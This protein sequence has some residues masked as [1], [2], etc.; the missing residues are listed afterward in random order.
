ML[1]A[2]DLS[3]N[4]IEGDIKEGDFAATILDAALKETRNRDGTMLVLTLETD[5][6]VRIVDRLNLINKSQKAEKIGR[7]RLKTLL[8]HCGLP[9]D[10][11]QYASILVGKRL[12]IRVK[13]ES[14]PDGNDY[15]RVAKY[16]SAQAPKGLSENLPPEGEAPPPGNTDDI[17]F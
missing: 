1:E 11:F 2:I 13:K 10:N 17:P 14:A 6:G 9:V 4:I 7:D 5:G 16:F 12:T 15:P 8:H 3:G